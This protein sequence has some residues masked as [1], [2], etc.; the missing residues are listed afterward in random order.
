MRLIYFV[1]LLFFPF[2]VYAESTFETEKASAF[3]IEKRIYSSGAISYY[4]DYTPVEKWD[5]NV[6]NLLKVP[7]TS[8]LTL[9]IDNSKN[10][11]TYFDI[12]LLEKM[13]HLQSF[14]INHVIVKTKCITAELPT[15]LGNIAFD[16][17]DISDEDCKI[18]SNL[19]NLRTLFIN[20]NNFKGRGLQY[21][22]KE[23][24]GEIDLSGSYIDESAFKALATYPSLEVLKMHN[25]KSLNKIQ[26]MYYYEKYLAKKKIRLYYNNEEN[27]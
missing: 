27:Q 3:T 19:K 13:N 24:I 14:A 8:I 9:N 5:M 21:F 4:V 20:G 17:T 2:F 23:S 7:F 10:K 6:F 1:L 18:F 25:L 26:I 12:K 22:Y 15:S 11:I 16:D